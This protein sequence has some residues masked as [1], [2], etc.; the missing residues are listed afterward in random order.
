MQLLAWRFFD[1]VPINEAPLLLSLEDLTETK[2]NALTKANVK[3]YSN[4]HKRSEN[5]YNIFTQRSKIA[6][7]TLVL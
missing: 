5:F 7:R 4:K 1:N 2:R 3:M 6:K